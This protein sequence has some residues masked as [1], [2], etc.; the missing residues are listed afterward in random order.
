[1]ETEQSSGPRHQLTC[2]AHLAQCPRKPYRGR[3]DE[4]LWILCDRL[5][6]LLCYWFDQGESALVQGTPNQSSTFP[7]QSLAQRDASGLLPDHPSRRSLVR[8]RWEERRRLVRAA[9]RYSRHA[10]EGKFLYR[11]CRPFLVAN[12]DRRSLRFLRLEVLTWFLLGSCRC[13]F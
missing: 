6:E 11:F 8:V 5:R 3:L 7:A 2:I 12:Q 4:L 10:R 9:C 1:M 13:H